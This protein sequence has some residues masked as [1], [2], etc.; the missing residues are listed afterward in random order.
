M[1]NFSTYDGLVTAVQEI[2]EDDSQEF[3]DYIPKAIELAQLRLMD[4]L[5]LDTISTRTAV[6]CTPSNALILKPTGYRF[7]NSAILETATG[8]Q[9]LKFAQA[10]Y[11]MDYW[12]VTTSVAT[13]AYIAP[14]Y[15]VNYFMVAPT[16]SSAYVISMDLRV[17]TPMISASYPSNYLTEHCGNALY[18]ATMKEQA[19]FMRNNNLIS[20]FEQSY[21]N[22]VQGINNRG[23]RNRRQDGGTASTTESG[24]NTLMGTK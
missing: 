24:K 13:P 20:V 3:L 10:N 2:S 16:P 6:T 14:D 12:P 18:F 11:L 1:A 23:R 22:A 19:V 21:M 15:D 5:D 17:D 9:P 4:E 8:K 7:L